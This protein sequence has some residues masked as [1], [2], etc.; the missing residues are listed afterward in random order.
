MASRKYS[1]VEM[2]VGFFLAFSA[3]LFV[4]MVVIYGRMSPIWRVRSE[5]HVAFSD[6]GGLKTDAPVRFNGVAVGRVRSMRML[7]LDAENIDRLPPLTRRDLASLP[8]AGEPIVGELRAVSDAEFDARC[9]AALLNHTMIEL[10][11]ELLQEGDVRRYRMNDRVHIVTTL[12]GDCA[13]EIIAGT[14][15]VNQPNSRQMLLG[16]SGDFFGNLGKSLSDVREI[17]NGVTD[18]V[19]GEDRRSIRKAYS[20]VASVQAHADK[21]SSMATGRTQDSAKKFEGLSD[22]VRTTLTRASESLES[23]RPRATRTF[24]SIQAGSTAVQDRLKSAQTESNAAWNEI[25]QDMSPIRADISAIT[26][27]VQPDLAQ[28]RTVFVQMYDRVGRMSTRVVDMRDTAGSAVTQ[29]DPDIQ[30]AFDALGN[31]LTN[32][33]HTGEAANENKDLMLG[34]RDAGENEFATVTDIY[35]RLTMSCRR[36]REAG[37]DVQE[38]AAVCGKLN[39]TSADRTPTLALEPGAGAALLKLAATRAALDVQQAAVEDYM[40]PPF[41]R[42]K[43]AWTDDVPLKK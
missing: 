42:K 28:T 11:L 21:I 26:A 22:Y 8:L 40:L 30:R 39:E 2:V 4:G 12:F 7:H 14:G 9:R 37:A 13:V 5:L 24:D 41:S 23:I 38:T 36:I 31:S 16:I 43:T 18:V 15:A 19:G 33:K 10:S 17:L 27:S 20:R 25:S 32:L 29:S 6:V 35:R 3:A 34:N 1:G